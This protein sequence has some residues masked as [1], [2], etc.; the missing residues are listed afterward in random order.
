MHSSAL[1]WQMDFITMRFDLHSILNRTEASVDAIPTCRAAR[2]EWSSP[3]PDRLP[4]PSMI[5]REPTYTTGIVKHSKGWCVQAS[6][7]ITSLLWID[8]YP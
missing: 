1:H 3:E 6:S 8:Q 4:V 7:R 2:L 5:F